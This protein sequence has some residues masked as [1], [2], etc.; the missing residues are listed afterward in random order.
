MGAI[1]FPMISGIFWGFVVYFYFRIFL[2]KKNLGHV[3]KISLCILIITMPII[4]NET[5]GLT[6]ISIY[7]PASF[8]IGIIMTVVLF[9]GKLNLKIIW[10]F[11]LVILDSTSRLAAM[12]VLSQTDLGMSALNL[13]NPTILFESHITAYLFL[14]FFVSAVKVLKKPIVVRLSRSDDVM[15]VTIPAL[16]VATMCKLSYDTASLGSKENF[17]VADFTTVSILLINI[18]TY[19]LFLKL[20]K[21]SNSHLKLKLAEQQLHIQAIHYAQLMKSRQTFLQLLHDE[22]NHL[23]CIDSLAEKG[24]CEM[25]HEYVKNIRECASIISKT[26]D[27]GHMIIDAVLDEKRQVAQNAGIKMNFKVLLPSKT[28]I[29][30]VDLCVLLGNAIDNAIEA[31]MRLKNQ[32]IKK[33]INIVLCMKNNHFVA[34]FSNP[35]DKD[36]DATKLTTSKKNK[37]LHGFGLRNIRSTVAKYGGNVKIVCADNIFKLDIIIPVKVPAK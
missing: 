27:T 5:V 15:L 26:V 34:M 18:I 10:S 3:R 2:D 31:C 16:S 9:K 8:F 30:N 13:K 19:F 33:E 35:V 17:M 11:L 6:K 12:L 14:L 29:D 24:N 36:I 21:Q 4:L 25:V 23:L 20:L 32:D 7:A 37:D 22:R 28:Y 1:I